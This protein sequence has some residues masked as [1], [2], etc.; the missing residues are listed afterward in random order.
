MPGT[1]CRDGRLVISAETSD[2]V[3]EI[4]LTP[5]TAAERG[6]VAGTAVWT[7]VK[8]TE[9]TSSLSARGATEAAITGRLSQCSTK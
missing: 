3:A 5:E 9:V 8:A 1:T 7:S 2:P 6:L 4:P